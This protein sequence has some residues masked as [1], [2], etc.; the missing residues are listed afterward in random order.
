M[1][2]PANIEKEN[3]ENNNI[4]NDNFLNDSTAFLDKIKTPII[5]EELYLKLYT[6]TKKILIIIIIISVFILYIHTDEFITLKNIT[7]K[8]NFTTKLKAKQK[9]RKYLDQCLE[10]IN[11][12]NQKFEIS[13]NPKITM[14]IPVY[15]T[16]EILK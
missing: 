7:D 12:N 8:E 16:G 14:I 11:I 15:N 6:S 13:L 5:L 10:E 4:L 3:E 2:I 1:N 9:G